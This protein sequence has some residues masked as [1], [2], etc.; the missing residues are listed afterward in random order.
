[1]AVQLHPGLGAKLDENEW[2]SVWHL[3]GLSTLRCGT[4]L[5]VAGPS[6]VDSPGQLLHPASSLVPSGGQR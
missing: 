4:V 6:S 1:M 2:G 3:V 5:A